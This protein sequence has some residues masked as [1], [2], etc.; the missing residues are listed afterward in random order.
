MQQELIKLGD[1]IRRMEMKYALRPGSI[2][3]ESRKPATVRAREEAIYIL[4]QETSYSWEEL[5]DILGR[6]VS[7]LLKAH[8]RFLSRT[9]KAAIT[10]LS[11]G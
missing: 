4:R 3:S 7:T 8:K 6:D 10:T 9:P 2:R 5:A 1:A 11:I